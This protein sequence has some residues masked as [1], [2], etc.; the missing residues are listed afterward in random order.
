MLWLILL[1]D[2][3]LQSATTLEK[4]IRLSFGHLVGMALERQHQ[5]QCHRLLRVPDESGLSYPFSLFTHVS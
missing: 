2:L 1:H 5:H 4:L 3:D